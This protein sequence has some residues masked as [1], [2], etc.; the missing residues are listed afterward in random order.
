MI[1]GGA[2]APTP[3]L[4]P[5]SAPTLPVGGLHPPPPEES[6]KDS[7]DGQQRRRKEEKEKKEDGR[8][9]GA[10]G[11]G[12]AALPGGGGGKGGGGGVGGEG[13]GQGG[14]RRGRKLREWTPSPAK[15]QTP[16]PQWLLKALGL[17]FATTRK[18]GVVPGSA[19]VSEHGFAEEQTVFSSRHH[20][21][22]TVVW[23]FHRLLQRLVPRHGESKGKLGRIA[24][25][26]R[27]METSPLR[28]L[29]HPS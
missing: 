4:A 28:P 24:L 5:A 8:E 29:L 13:R 1:G 23:I 10:A 27:G 2:T 11:E 12:G 17:T 7:S 22:M 25:G 15:L 26:E 9:K 16:L 6:S 18:A 20:S 3:A 14:G 19:Q 21:H